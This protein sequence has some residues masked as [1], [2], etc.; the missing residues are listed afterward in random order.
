MH[1]HFCICC[2]STCFCSHL[3]HA[4]R[5]F[6]LLCAQWGGWRIS[7]QHTESKAGDAVTIPKKQQ[8]NNSAEY[9]CCSLQLS[10]KWRSR[11]FSQTSN[12]SQSS[13]FS[14]EVSHCC[15]WYKQVTLLHQGDNDATYSLVLS[16]NRKL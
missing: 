9:L 15:R 2:L 16:V 7:S 12:H 3:L 14:Q 13:V 6:E 5:C 4:G 10:W 11:P 1:F 8:Q